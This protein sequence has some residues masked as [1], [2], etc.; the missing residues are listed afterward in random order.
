MQTLEG[1]R[2]KKRKHQPIVCITAYD[3][4]FASL[5]ESVEVDSILVGD[6][7]GMVVQGGCD[8][9]NVKMEDILYHTRCV[10]CAVLDTMIMVDMP[11]RSYEDENSAR[12]NAALIA[13]IDDKVK[14][15]KLET[16]YKH[17]GFIED[18]R[19]DGIC[20][21]AHVGYLPQHN[22][23]SDHGKW[24]LDRGQKM[25]DICHQC[26]E[27]GAEL[28]VAECVPPEWIEKIKACCSLPIIGIGSGSACDG[29]ILVLSDVL[30]ISARLPSFSSA[31]RK[32]RETVRNIIQEYKD[33]V[34]SG[35]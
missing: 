11:Y 33:N 6:S 24:S 28:L 27:S 20:V 5:V 19:K 10:T 23:Q 3:A 31:Y 16:D 15:V 18:I 30:G 8:T 14:I 9:R 7:L 32:N 12:S 35:R 1:F 26:E 34:L 29:Q 22:M 21:C 4:S 13:D 25:L 2:K 17:V